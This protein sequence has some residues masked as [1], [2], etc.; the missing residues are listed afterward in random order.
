MSTMT[1]ASRVVHTHLLSRSGCLKR[2]R[3]RSA[4]SVSERSAEHTNV[5]KA[6][7]QRSLAVK[8]GLR[9]HSHSYGGLASAE[10]VRPRNR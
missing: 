8:P 1:V 9:C 6:H 3:A 10:A 5:H 4:Q 2:I 7:D